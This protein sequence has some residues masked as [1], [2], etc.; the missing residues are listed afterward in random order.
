MRKRLEITG[1]VLRA[2]P[3]YEKATTM[4]EFAKSVVPLFEQKLV[5]PVVD[6]IVSFDEIV[7]G[8]NALESNQTFGKVVIAMGG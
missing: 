3:D 4:A 2:R 1:T 6:R 8:Y 5:A 7:T